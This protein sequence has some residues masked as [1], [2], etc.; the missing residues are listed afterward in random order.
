[1]FS[2]HANT[3]GNHSVAGESKCSEVL[4]VNFELGNEVWDDFDDE[5]LVEIMSF[6]ADAEKTAVSGKTAFFHKVVSLEILWIFLFW[7][8]R[9][10]FLAFCMCLFK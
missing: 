8:L 5:S 10:L 9:L 6:S 3:S 1:M 4:D 2:R 7:S